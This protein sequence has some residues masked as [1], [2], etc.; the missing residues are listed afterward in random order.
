M[1]LILFNKLFVDHYVFLR[2]SW[3]LH[4]IMIIELTQRNKVYTCV[5]D[6]SSLFGTFLKIMTTIFR[7]VFQHERRSPLPFP[8]GDAV[9]LMSETS[10]I[11]VRKNCATIW[12]VLVWKTVL[13]RKIN[14]RYKRQK[15]VVQK[16]E[17]S[18]II[19]NL[20]LKVKPFL[21]A[22]ISHYAAIE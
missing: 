11:F 19:I 8:V 9:F 21:N 22:C 12:N 13:K 15:K 20:S 4:V 2:S 17:K 18:H 7:Y 1:G 16:L 10:L 6:V 5:S 3:W 14:W